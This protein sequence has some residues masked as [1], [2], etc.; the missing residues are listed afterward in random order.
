MSTPEANETPGLARR[1]RAVSWK[2]AF[3]LLLG[4]FGFG[5]LKRGIQ[6]SRRETA[7]LALR[8]EFA[9]RGQAAVEAVRA[10]LEGA[11]VSWQ[12][13]DTGKGWLARCSFPVDGTP[14]GGT[15]LPRGASAT[16]L[17]VARPAPT[18]EFETTSPVPGEIP[19]VRVV[20]WYP[21]ESTDA[22]ALMSWE[23]ELL[24]DAR[25]LAALESG[26][27]RDAAEALVRAGIELAWDPVSPGPRAVHGISG[28]LAAA[29]D[30]TRPLRGTGRRW[31]SDAPGAPVLS[32]SPRHPSFLVEFSGPPGSRRADVRLT[33]SGRPAGAAEP[34]LREFTA[35][36]TR[37][38]N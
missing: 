8:L 37:L 13:D 1:F 28:D 32:R 21:A 35:V 12:D 24:A 19:L 17:L 10:D 20:A 6:E 16:M 31:C 18:F 25:A 3:W 26:A 33:L 34:V 23:S 30:P 9:E 29:D 11:R 22:P 2:I 5:W 27:R 36:A 15:T 4:G 38:A 7:V 14:A